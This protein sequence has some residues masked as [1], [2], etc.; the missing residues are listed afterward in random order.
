MFSI[1]APGLD[2]GSTG[3]RKFQGFTSRQEMYG[4]RT[5]DEVPYNILPMASTE[6]VPRQF[7]IYYNV[8]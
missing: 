3:S 6:R 8:S 7:P 4:R 2:L 5:A 1:L